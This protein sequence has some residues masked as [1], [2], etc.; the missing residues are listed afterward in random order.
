MSKQDTDLLIENLRLNKTMDSIEG[1][2]SFNN[3]VFEHNELDYFLIPTSGENII[4]FTILSSPNNANITGHFNSDRTTN[5]KKN[6][7]SHIIVLLTKSQNLM[8]FTSKVTNDNI[9]SFYRCLNY[10]TDATK[11]NSNDFVNSVLLPQQYDNKY[12]NIYFFSLANDEYIMILGLIGICKNCSN[13]KIRPVCKYK[14]ADSKASNFRDSILYS[15]FL[16][17]GLSFNKSNEKSI[18]NEIYKQLFLQKLPTDVFLNVY[19]LNNNHLTIVKSLLSIYFDLIFYNNDILFL[20]DE[21]VKDAEM[22]SNKYV[23]CDDKMSFLEL[24]PCFP[25]F[26]FVDSHNT[27]Q[28][29]ALPI[30]TDISGNSHELVYSTHENKVENFTLVSCIKSIPLICFDSKQ[31]QLKKPLDAFCAYPWAWHSCKPWFAY[32]D[33]FQGILTVIFLELNFE[34]FFSVNDWNKSFLNENFFSI[35]VFWT[36]TDQICLFNI[37]TST[38]KMF[39][40]DNSNC[41]NQMTKENLSIHESQTSSNI[42]FS[43]DINLLRVSLNPF[44]N[45]LILFHLD[46]NG[47][48]QVSFRDFEDESKY[49]GLTIQTNIL[50]DDII[51]LNITKD[52]K[53]IVLNQDQTISQFHLSFSAN[54]NNST[55]K[56]LYSMINNS[57]YIIPGKIKRLLHFDNPNALETSKG[58]MLDFY[59]DIRFFDFDFDANSDLQFEV[60]SEI[61]L[62]TSTLNNTYILWVDRCKKQFVLQKHQLSIHSTAISSKNAL[63]NDETIDSFFNDCNFGKFTSICE[64]LL[65]NCLDGFLD[66][67]TIDYAPYNQ[68]V[69]LLYNLSL[70]F[71]DFAISTEDKNKSNELDLASTY[72][73]YNRLDVLTS[74]DNQSNIGKGLQSDLSNM[75]FGGFNPSYGVSSV[76]SND[77]ASD[78]GL[79]S[80][81]IDSFADSFLNDDGYQHCS[82]FEDFLQT[83]LEET[84]VEEENSHELPPIEIVVENDIHSNDFDKSIFHQFAEVLKHYDYNCP[85]ETIKLSKE[86]VLEVSKVLKD[87]D[88]CPLDIL[89][90][91]RYRNTEVFC[92]MAS[93]VDDQ[94]LFQRILGINSLEDLLSFELP[95]WFK[96][97][98]NILE[99]LETFWKQQLRIEGEP[100]S[101]LIYLVLL[102]RV[103]EM[104]GICRSLNEKPLEKFFNL[105]EKKFLKMCSANAFASVSKGKYF[106]AIAFFLICKDYASAF[107]IALKRL[108]RKIGLS[109]IILIHRIFQIDLPL[110]EDFSRYEITS[111]DHLDGNMQEIKNLIKDYDETHE[112]FSWYCLND[113]LINQR[114]GFETEFIEEKK[115]EI[116]AN[117]IINARE[118]YNLFG[119][120]YHAN[121]MFKLKNKTLFDLIFLFNQCLNVFLYFSNIH[122]FKM[123]EMFE[124]LNFN[125]LYLQNILELQK[126]LG[127]DLLKSHYYCDMNDL[128]KYNYFANF[129]DSLLCS[130]IKDYQDRNMNLLIQRINL[131]V[132]EDSATFEVIDNF[133]SLLSYDINNSMND[134]FDFSKDHH[135]E[136]KSIFGSHSP[137]NTKEFFDA[138]A[139]FLAI[140]LCLVNENDL[141]SACKIGYHFQLLNST[142][143]VRFFHKIPDRLTSSYHLVMTMFKEVL[144]NQST[145]LLPLIQSFEQYLTAP[146]VSSMCNFAEKI[147]YNI[148]NQYAIYSRT[149]PSISIETFY[150]TPRILNIATNTLKNSI[151][152]NLKLFDNSL[153]LATSHGLEIFEIPPEFFLRQL[154]I[155]SDSVD[156]SNIS[157]AFTDTSMGFRDSKQSSYFG[158]IDVS[159]FTPSEISTRNQGPLTELK[160]DTDNQPKIEVNSDFPTI[161]IENSLVIDNVISEANEDETTPIDYELEI[162]KTTEVPSTPQIQ[163]TYS[164]LPAEARSPSTRSHSVSPTLTLNSVPPLSPTPLITDQNFTEKF[165]L[166]SP[167]LSMDLHPYIGLIVV[168]TIDGAYLTFIDSETSKLSEQSFWELE[169]PI[170]NNSNKNEIVKV[171][172][173]KD[174]NFVI[175]AIQN[176]VLVYCLQKLLRNVYIKPCETFENSKSFVVL[177]Y[178]CGINLDN[179]K[180]ITDIC[181]ITNTIICVVG[182]GQIN[183]YLLDFMLN[184][185]HR[186]INSLNMKNDITCVLYD[187]KIQTILFGDSIGT[188]YVYFIEDNCIFKRIFSSNI[189]KSAIHAMSINNLHS[190]IAVGSLDGTIIVLN[191]SNYGVIADF[192]K[193]HKGNIRV[194]KSIHKPKRGVLDLFWI[195]NHLIS[196]GVDSKML[197]FFPIDQV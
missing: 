11:V 162:Y 52:L 106:L 144:T 114:L 188:L 155:Y 7:M 127:V 175:V 8:F 177:K 160:F 33:R 158:D 88:N 70:N 134:S 163:P 120:I 36:G 172:F 24:H 176:I 3:R 166:N 50:F 42:Q 161:S 78:L 58:I 182:I 79:N 62:F 56:F 149:I 164:T 4:D 98:Q 46:S 123:F 43:G 99:L 69:A 192:T 165:F 179:L 12:N 67:N 80:V 45:C 129:D 184:C 49:Q 112:S 111:M 97:K 121:E 63:F 64:I 178:F 39:T 47:F 108:E 93:V 113:P 41:L 1:G 19:I 100:L 156:N 34:I 26:V 145:V 40:I 103:D 117:R 37:E 169:S 71:S 76:F 44:L 77:S 55:S 81:S 171:V 68:I 54:S 14:F 131:G 101:I 151:V 5:Y 23:L 154:P 189:Q 130:L 16:I 143:P 181:F 148:I 115:R 119:L 195:D 191:A 104:S 187:Q 185:D 20:S 65:C 9:I 105:P 29:C 141:V 13:L 125:K 48:I 27:L 193:C 102:G 59:E 109:F 174:G 2:F 122:F 170:L 157:D 153:I 30:N 25:Y 82:M 94:L 173:S 22:L 190:M 32:F 197:V 118:Q 95:L 194:F 17:T 186:I 116:L 152:F 6:S 133:A 18:V 57:G 124:I 10:K 196:T 31:T 89:L 159:P 85:F 96:S 72:G 91:L 137:Y 51:D 61:E 83:G 84:V 28:I 128:L 126:N 168:G 90:A 139:F 147:I 86:K 138:L 146:L 183:C 15:S 35:D 136:R 38:V 140:F 74:Y 92:I 73:S 87:G 135:D 110:I 150:P 21:K 167:I 53:L 180:Y 132:D 66:I 107:N 142:Y 60:D 75:F